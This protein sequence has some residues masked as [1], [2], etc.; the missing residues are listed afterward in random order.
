MLLR[1]PPS[2]K[3]PIVITDLLVQ[4]NDNVERSA[5]LFA[6]SYKTIVT[7]GDGLNEVQVERTFPTRFESTVE[8]TLKQWK[9]KKGAVIT[10]PKCVLLHDYSSHL[11]TDSSS[12]DVADIEEPC[13]HEV[14]FGGMCANCGK[15]MTQFS[16]NTETLDANRATIKMVHDNSALTVSQNEAKRVEEEAKL[17]LLASKKLSLVVDLDQ[18]IIHATVDPT[19]LEWQQDVNNP[20]H[21]AVKDVKAFQLIDDGPGARGCWYYIKLRPGLMEFLKNISQLYELH[22]YTMGTRAYAQSIANIVDSDRKIFGD[23]ILSRDESG[24]LTAK[25]LQRLFP[26][27]TK[28]VVIIDDRG[29]VWNW[30]HNLIK[31][32]P[33]DFFVGIGDINSSFLPK[34]PTLRPSPKP[35]PV[36]LPELN[37]DVTVG[38]TEKETEPVTN[39]TTIPTEESNDNG[40]KLSTLEQLVNMAS[41]DDPNLLQSQASQQNEALAAQLQERPLLQKQKQL[42]LEDEAADVGEGP[43]SAENGE[44][45]SETT[46]HDS[47]KHRHHLLEDHDD[48]LAYLEARLRAVHRAFFEEYERKLAGAQGGRVAALR[49]EK[50]IPVGDTR[51]I[52]LRL[53]PDVKDVMPQMKHRVFEGVVIVFSGVVPLNTDLQNADISLWAKSFG[54]RISSRIGKK[55]TH[56]IAARN[57]TAKVRQAAR[58]PKIRIV[59]TQWLFD[60]IAQW[61]RLDEAPYLIPVHPEDKREPLGSS[62]SRDGVYFD[63]QEN[64]RMLLSSSDEQSDAVTED[65]DTTR[66]DLRLQTGDTDDNSLMPDD[67]VDDQSPIG[68]SS[69]DW[70][71]INDELAEFMGDDDTES[72]T[73]SINSESSTR[74]LERDRKRKRGV[75]ESEDDS[76]HSS[77]AGSYLAQRKRL[78]QDRPT[79][80]KEVAIA[81]SNQ[82]TDIPTPVESQGEVSIVDSDGGD[83][84]EDDLE[85]E[86]EAELLKEDDDNGNP[87]DGG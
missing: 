12:I 71:A 81:S 77:E 40:A 79:Q 36:A 87:D 45:Q 67:I 9:I 27:D 39:G 26:V 18:T 32:N 50:K 58:I 35:V 20:N 70:S 24:S 60:C 23:R 52:D 49:G 33:Y 83:G 30:S 59:T 84:F 65:E 4:P 2:L 63:A 47:A 48:E 46:S 7:E 72:D 62:P 41:S 57:R 3:Y 38:E 53:V 10:K 66:F 22:I 5:P 85:A 11:E 21:N 55:T 82:S 76:D 86:L 80:L 13:A 68:G 56:V 78:A 15:D 37:N 14:Q 42:D 74:S 54:A 31:V 19:V 17:R 6:Y 1:L 25:S 44:G 69:E 29:D 43:E 16:Y 73:E 34:R 61:E 28:M 64:D 8:G 75:E 51:T